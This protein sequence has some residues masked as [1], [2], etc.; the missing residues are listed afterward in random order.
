MSMKAVKISWRAMQRKQLVTG[1]GHKTQNTQN[2]QLS[3][4]FS[5]YVSD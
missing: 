2:K 4:S 1:L 3:Q 5:A